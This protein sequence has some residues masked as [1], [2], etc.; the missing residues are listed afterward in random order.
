METL[1]GGTRGVR[2]PP[3]FN[4]TIGTLRG[5]LTQMRMFLKSNLKKYPSIEE[6]TQAGATQLKGSALKWFE[7]IAR[8]YMENKE[9]TQKAK[10]KEIFNNYAKFKA[11]ILKGFKETDKAQE[12]GNKIA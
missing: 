10:T 8:D 5:F 3:T 9:A 7:P 11:Y 1:K 6:W 2:R 12:A 4:G